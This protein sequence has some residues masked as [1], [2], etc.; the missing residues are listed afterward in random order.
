MFRTKDS[1][2]RDWCQ[3]PAAHLGCPEWSPHAESNRAT[4]STKARSRHRVEATFA[5][6]AGLEPA[7]GALTV[8][9]LT[10]RA[11][12]GTGRRSRAYRTL[13]KSGETDTHEA[14]SRPVRLSKSSNVLRVSRACWLWTR[15][16]SNLRPSG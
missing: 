14:P 5:V 12:Y 2:L 15:E 3:R 8:R 9:S 10:D 6:E 1:N 7:Y 4:G 16:E 13:Y 11:L